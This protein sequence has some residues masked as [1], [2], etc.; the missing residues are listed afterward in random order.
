MKA[1]T[2]AIIILV[3][4]VVVSLFSLYL[5]RQ[6]N[7]NMFTLNVPY[8]QGMFNKPK[9]SKILVLQDGAYKTYPEYGVYSNKINKAYCD[10]W[11]YEYKLI[12][13]DTL[14]TMP[15]YW[16]KVKD[17]KDQLPN[18]DAV[19]YVDMDAVITDFDSSID[20]LLDY[21]DT[22]QN[23]K[24]DIYIGNDSVKTNI[25][26]G[27]FLVRNTYFGNMFMEAW[28]ASCLDQDGQLV[29]KCASWTFDTTSQSWKCPNCF[30]ADYQYEQGTFNYLAQLYPENITILNQLFSNQNENKLSFILHLMGT[31]KDKTEVL[32]AISEKLKL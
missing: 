25:N 6:S 8:T 16:L 20:G 2:V 4:I 17:L 5:L 14:D 18:Y 10:K 11:G 32:K 28:L 26:T 24:S 30:H 21:I 9:S 12:K 23:S 3:F 7:F 31:R 22:K 15:P 27:V 29:N 19:L 13:Y 1:Y